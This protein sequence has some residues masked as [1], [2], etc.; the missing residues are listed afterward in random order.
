M[1]HH[2]IDGRFAI[3]QDRWKLEVCPGSGGWSKPNDAAAQKQGLP[4]LQLYD[5]T[6]DA[7]EQRNLQAE[8]PEVVKTLM[9]LLER[10]VAVVVVATTLFAS[11]L[12]VVGLVV[13]GVRLVVDPRA[14]E[15]EGAP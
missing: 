5:M 6:A 1:I 12:V 14:R 2:S 3:R 4:D 7:G 13:E 8:Q 10:Q 15:G 9:A 11:L